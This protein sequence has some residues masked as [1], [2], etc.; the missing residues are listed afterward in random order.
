MWES[1]TSFMDSTLGGISVGQLAGA[2]IAVLAGFLGK[3][4]SGAFLVHARRV[5]ARSKSKLDDILV[6]ALT[7]PL[8]WAFVVG[9]FYIGTQFLPI[10]REPTDIPV[11][12]RLAAKGAMV[13][14]IVWLAVRLSDRLCAFWQERV[15]E[16]ESRAD[17]QTIPMVRTILRILL[18]FLGICLVLQNMGYSV[19]GLLAGLGLGGAALAL[20]SK[21][22]LA[23]VF[24]AIV[25]FWDRPFRVGDWIEIAGVEG[26]VETIGLRTTRLRTFE[27]SLVTLPNMNLTTASICNWSKMERRRIK[28]TV[29]LPSNLGW[30][31]AEAAVAAIRDLFRANP[32]VLQDSVEVRLDGFGPSSLDVLV[33]GF[34]KVTQWGP[35]LALKERLLLDILRQLESQG[36]PLATPVTTVHMPAASGGLQDDPHHQRG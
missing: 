10:P 21:D 30:Q 22:T 25:I 2:A 27:D 11:L 34:T 5:A 33:H 29:C 3:V 28:L 23:N 16:S 7:T 31:K 8:G 6:E 18:I 19:G 35:Y 20:A 24:G 17:N 1:G 13:F 26:T 9:G 4:L 12:I 15:A 14:L 36:I 32:E